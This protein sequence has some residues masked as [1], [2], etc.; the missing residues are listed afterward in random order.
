MDQA[1]AVTLMVQVRNVM[2]ALGL[3]FQLICRARHPLGFYTLSDLEL[4]MKRKC[5][6]LP[7]CEG[8]EQ[9]REL[10][11]FFLPAINPVVVLEQGR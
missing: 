1:L 10:Q 6:Q 11:L 9:H 3:C 7:D 5:M 2:L 8:E 4:Q